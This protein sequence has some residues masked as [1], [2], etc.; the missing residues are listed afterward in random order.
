MARWTAIGATA[1]I[2]A[3]GTFGVGA[4]IVASGQAY[5]TE[6]RARSVAVEF[7]RSQ[8]ERQ[9]DR[10]CRLFSHRFYARHHL[11]DRQTCVALLRVSFMWSGQI[12]FR[13]GA[14][15]RDGDRFVVRAI[16][17]GAPGQIV[18]V[19]ESGDLKILAVRGE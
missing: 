8:N 2:S 3:L 10:T 13:I 19:R 17:D 14:V 1:A 15:E 16:A 5:A 11:P 7:F 18:L 4:R 9:Y 12:E 6:A